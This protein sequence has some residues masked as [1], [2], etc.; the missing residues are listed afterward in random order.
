[1]IE[2]KK[3]E[4]II[5]ELEGRKDYIDLDI[6]G[7]FENQKSVAAFMLSESFSMLKSEEY[8]LLWY[9]LYVIVLSFDKG[10]IE[11]DIQ[12]IESYEDSNWEIFNSMG[13]KPFREKL[14]FIF[15]TYPQE[16]LLA[17]VEDML[18]NDDDNE[19]SAVSREII[20]VAC[21][22]IIDVYDAN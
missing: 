1:M 9:M 12:Q 19:I 3:I 14:D 22:T 7:F 16:D 4:S 13:N 5:L 2:E 6:K 17:F 11:I 15:D 10:D 20:F 8:D 18:Q 21:K